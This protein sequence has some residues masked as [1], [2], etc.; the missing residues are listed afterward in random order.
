[1]KIRY[2]IAITVSALCLAALS[3]CYS[4]KGGSTPPHLN[5]VIIPPAEDVSGFFKATVRED[6]TRE[7]VRRFRDDNSLR[8]IDDPNAD[9]RLDV[10]I[11]SIRNNERRNIGTN[12]LETVRGVVV[13]ARASFIDNVKKREIFHDHSFQGEAQYDISQGEAGENEAIRTAITILTEKILNETV[14]GW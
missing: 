13:V 5:T 2:P 7:L 10:T 12:E 6:L 4:F 9:S 8:V 11:T 1:M 14:A 3:G